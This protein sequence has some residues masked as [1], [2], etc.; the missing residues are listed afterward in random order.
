MCAMD[1]LVRS[2]MRLPAPRVGGYLRIAEQCEQLAAAALLPLE[3]SEYSARAATFRRLAARWADQPLAAD[4]GN[5]T[6]PR[7][8]RRN[9]RRRSLA[10]K[11][12]D[13]VRQRRDNS[14]AT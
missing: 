12:N 1:R 5:V 8:S 3:K 11:S 14:P 6:K 4:A 2:D 9:R 10:I 7:S 13:K